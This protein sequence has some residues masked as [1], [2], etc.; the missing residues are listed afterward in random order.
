MRRLL[1]VMT[2]AL[3]LALAGQADA[4]RPPDR[5]ASNAIDA[6]VTLGLSIHYDTDSNLSLPRCSHRASGWACPV[7]VGYRPVAS[8]AGTPY[9]RCVAVALAW[10]GHW[11][12]DTAASSCP[13]EWLGIREDHR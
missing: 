11:R 13:A 9:Q 4:A 1:V 3:V 8:P 7:R 10:P 5:V 6:A 2:A 12:F